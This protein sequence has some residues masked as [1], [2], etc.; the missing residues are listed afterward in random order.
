MNIK[1]KSLLKR[2]WLP[3]FLFVGCFIISAQQKLKKTDTDGRTGISEAS[4]AEKGSNDVT[5]SRN[6]T[7]QPAHWLMAV[8]LGSSLVKTT[9]Q[10]LDKAP[11]YVHLD[12]SDERTNFVYSVNTLSQV[13]SDLGR[14]STLIGQKPS[15]TS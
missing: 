5:P 11:G 13:D 12:L 4:N 15:G 14:L 8:D 10:K 6:S 7:N 1:I 3:L 2:F 9:N